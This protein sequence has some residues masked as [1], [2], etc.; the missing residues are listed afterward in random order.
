M[1]IGIIGGSFNP[2]HKLHRQ[3]GLEV[4]KHHLVD[5][6]IYVP[7]GD[8]YA[9]ENLLSGEIR[10]QMVSL[11]CAGYPNMEVS[12]YE[13]KKKTSYTYQTLDY[14][15]KKYPKDE[16]YFVLSTDLILDIENWKKPDYI[17][18]HYHLLGLKRKGFSQD[19]L[20]S[21]YSRYPESIKLYDFQMEELSST[22]IREKRKAK[23]EKDLPNLLGK[24]VYDFI[25]QYHLYE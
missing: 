13:V 6:V 10:F 11:M 1:R 24:R 5:K 18:S 8:G 16:I 7:T 14:F 21:I 25:C 3:M 17:L 19:H 12:D 22:I 23:D 15:Q 9:K 20:P 2:P 4:L